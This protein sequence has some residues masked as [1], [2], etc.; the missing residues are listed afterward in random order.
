MTPKGVEFVEPATAV[1]S[2]RS[3]GVNVEDPRATA[4]HFG[5]FFISA[6]TVSEYVA[7]H[8]HAGLEVVTVEDAFQIAQIVSEQEPLK[9][10]LA[11]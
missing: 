4:C 7:L 6:E 3:R 8:P 9:S 5:H 2:N 11:R 1:M 10:I